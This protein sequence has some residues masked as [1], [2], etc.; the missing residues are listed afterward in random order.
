MSQLPIIPHFEPWP[1][2]EQQAAAE[3]LAEQ[4]LRERP[5]LAIDEQFRP[6][7]VDRLEDG[8]A[9]QLDDL[10]GIA[11]FDH[12]YDVTFMQDRARLR[13]AGDDIVASCTPEDPAYERYCHDYLGIGLPT[14]L[15][16]RPARHPV[17]LAC[18][19]WLDRA[20]RRT[21]VQ[22]IRSGNLA[23]VHPHMGIFAVWELADLLRRASRR[24]VKV[25]APPP[26]VTNFAN[27]KLA[28]ADAARRLFGES[29]VP[30]TEHTGSLATLASRVRDLAG[31][32]RI[33]AIKL[34]DSAG[35]SGNVVAR[36][37]VFRHASLPV[38]EATL[39]ALLSRVDW[40]VGSPLLLSPWETDVVCAPSAQLWIPPEPEGPPVVEGLFEQVIVGDEGFFIGSRPAQFRSDLAEEI[41]N[42]CWLLGRFY[43][44]LG[45]VGRCSFDMLLVGA[46][47]EQG[48]LEFVECNGRWGGTSTPMT[49]MNR[50]V[51]DW[52]RQPYAARECV[53]E[54]LS[55]QSL[56]DLLEFFAS[57]LYDVRTGRGRLIFYNPGRM[58]AR[59]GINALVL[60]RS[61]TEADQVIRDEIPKRLEEFVAKASSGAQLRP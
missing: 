57:D 20:V 4:I 1:A 55:R 8:P 59:S 16:P 6:L 17:Q 43:Q 33:I 53:V 26:G 40:Q 12:V 19:C 14:W 32:A 56:A 11:L 23:V 37:E 15:H 34:P 50:I 13:A 42:R 61:W 36:A 10:S 25:I 39:K 30:P 22:A 29:F 44:R 27:D 2:P 5:E 58:Q 28:F 48:R 52:A 7:V 60:S 49:L 38:I 18:A 21:L 54:G 47:L 35:G 41:A 31:S 24:P 45:Y 3:A 9:L 46:S 51:G